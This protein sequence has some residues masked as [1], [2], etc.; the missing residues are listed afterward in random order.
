MPMFIS[1]AGNMKDGCPNKLIYLKHMIAFMA[2]QVNSLLIIVLSLTFLAPFISP[3]KFDN[4]PNYKY[5][6]HGS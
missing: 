2:R 6:Y 5:T 1:K 4:K 3:S